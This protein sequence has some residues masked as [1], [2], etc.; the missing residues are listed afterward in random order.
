MHVIIM[1]TIYICILI[2]I[3]RTSYVN[4]TIMRWGHDFLRITG[5]WGGGYLTFG[6]NGENPNVNGRTHQTVNY[7]SYLIHPII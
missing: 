5:G 3:P 6:D 1:D 2:T 4:A 7:L